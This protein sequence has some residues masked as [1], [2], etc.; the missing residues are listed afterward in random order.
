MLADDDWAQLV[1]DAISVRVTGRVLSN[2]S[3]EAALR[4]L[5]EAEG[6]RAERAFSIA[7]IIAQMPEFSLR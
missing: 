2:A 4:L 1:I 6:T 5:L 7:P 3:N